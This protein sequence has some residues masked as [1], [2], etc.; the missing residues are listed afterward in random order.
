[1]DTFH[2]YLLQKFVQFEK[3]TW[4]C[5]FKNID[6]MHQNLA[7]I[8]GTVCYNKKRFIALIPVALG[9]QAVDYRVGHSADHL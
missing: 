9:P 1:M 2:I 8:N 5:S 3:G 7:K 4:D 6:L